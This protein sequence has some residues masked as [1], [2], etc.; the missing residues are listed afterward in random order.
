MAFTGAVVKVDGVV[1]GVGFRFW[2][3]RVAREYEVTG[4]VANLPDGSVE[5]VAEGDRGIVNDFLDVL[6]VGPTYAHISGIKVEWYQEPRGF[7][8]FTI[9][10]KGA[11]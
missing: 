2:C 8:E 9:E 10:Y 3:L 6:K 7:K 1:Q 5:V 11:P 4:Y